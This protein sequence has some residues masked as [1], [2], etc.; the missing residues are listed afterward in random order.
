MAKLTKKQAKDEAFNPSILI[1]KMKNFMRKTL[2]ASLM[3][4]AV[5]SLNV[6]A[7]DLLQVYKD[8]LTNDAQYA[9]A[10]ASLAAGQEKAPQGL[11]LLL[12]SIGVS[13]GTPVMNRLASI[14]MP[15]LMAL[16]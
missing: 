7:A 8:A 13:G 14:T 3:A 16:L 4:S 12:P 2:I 11:A 9:S 10:R 5:F 6:N 1:A 15:T